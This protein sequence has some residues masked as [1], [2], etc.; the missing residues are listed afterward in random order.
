MARGSSQREAVVT[1]RG[2]G[3]RGYFQ[4]LVV[5]ACVSLGLSFP[6]TGCSSHHGIGSGNAVVGPGGGVLR[7][8]DGLV[9]LR[10]P[11]GALSSPAPIAI[12]P[13]M[14]APPGALSGT[15]DISPEVTLAAPAELTISY[16]TSQ[17]GQTKASSL[18]LSS[19]WGNGWV[20][21][22]STSV[23][24]SRHSATVRTT[25]VTK[26]WAVTAP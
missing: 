25:D 17:L 19:V 20:P 1:E 10:I 23:D 16:S 8:A 11:A 21:Q 4:G 22:P 24:E 5:A 15:Y 3:G 2:A 18:K 13:V 26:I 14:Y 12:A 6:S 7:S 9:T